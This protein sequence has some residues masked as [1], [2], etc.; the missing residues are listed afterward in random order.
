MRTAVQQ[1]SRLP[2]SLFLTSLS[3]TLRDPYL[4]QPKIST[5]FVA[6][7]AALTGLGR[8]FPSLVE[9]QRLARMYLAARPA[10]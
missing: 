6:L 9:K 3:Q 1:G 8:T 4:R 5:F 10:R 7:E 2:A